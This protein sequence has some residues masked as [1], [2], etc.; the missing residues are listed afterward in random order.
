MSEKLKFRF[1]KA[2]D[3]SKILYFIKELAKYVKMEDKVTATE[4][5]IREKIFKKERAEIIFVLEGD[6]EVGFALFFTTFSSFTCKENIYLEDLVILPEYRGKGYGR[7]ML[8]YLASL[9]VE[10]NC[11]KLK[12]D[13]LNWNKSS[14]DFYL[15]L[16]A[17]PVND[18]TVYVL[19]GDALQK[20]GK[21]KSDII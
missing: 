14:M 17:E 8:K 7:A 10:R 18:S 1:A 12:W 2:E 15:S 3:S 9:T 4:E 6:K 19:S 13:C 5:M 16:G 21:I 20:M 11:D